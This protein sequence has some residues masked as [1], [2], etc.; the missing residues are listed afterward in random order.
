MGVAAT[1]AS[2]RGQ[3]SGDAPLPFFVPPSV[4]PAKA[5]AHGYERLVMRDPSAA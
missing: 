5:G 2:D 4:I 1:A 3:G